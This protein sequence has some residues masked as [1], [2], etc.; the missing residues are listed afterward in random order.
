MALQESD[1]M[2]SIIHSANIKE[3]IQKYVYR[4]IKPECT[5]DYKKYMNGVDN[6][7]QY[8]A[9]Y[10]VIRKTVKWSKKLF[11]HFLQ[12][13]LVNTLLLLFCKSTFLQFM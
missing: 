9:L 8:L 11:F 5:T 10:P 7:D 12:C 13:T 4:K 3:D 1:N 6:A 2:I